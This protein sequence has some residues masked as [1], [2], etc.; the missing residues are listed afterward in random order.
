MRHTL[1]L[2]AVAS[3]AACLGLVRAPAVA[4]TRCPT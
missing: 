1:L 2:A 3:A 4:E